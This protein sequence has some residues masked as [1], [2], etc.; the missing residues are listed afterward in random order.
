MYIYENHLGGL[1]TDEDYLD[2]EDLYCEEC[3]DSDWCIGQAETKEEAWE[4]LKDETD[5]N[6]SGGFEYEYVQNFIDINFKE[7]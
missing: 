3:G 2:Y 1:Y 4:L 5:I 7:E 6:G